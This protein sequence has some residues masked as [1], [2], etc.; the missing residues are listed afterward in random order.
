MS[1]DSDLRTP[2]GNRFFCVGET[3]HQAVR[4]EYPIHVRHRP[5]GIAARSGKQRTYFQPADSLRIGVRAR[6]Q[7]RQV[8]ENRRVDIDFPLC[9]QCPYGKDGELS[10]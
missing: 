7:F 8:S 2:S 5:V 3:L 1:A 4:V 6:K 9:A 10:R